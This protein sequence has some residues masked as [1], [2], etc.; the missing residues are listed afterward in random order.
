MRLQQL[1]LRKENNSDNTYAAYVSNV[2][3]VTDQLMV[4]ASLRVDRFQ[5]KGVYDIT[6]GEIKGGLSNSGTQ[7]GPYSQTALSP[8]LGLVYEILK[9]KVSLFGK[10]YEWI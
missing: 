3:N 10:L 7:T 4:M 8:K 9:N 6:T 2:F 1:L 5:F